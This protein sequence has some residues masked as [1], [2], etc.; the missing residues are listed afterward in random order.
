M[1]D[2]IFY[3]ACFKYI[4]SFKVDLQ[5]IQSK[6]G[7]VLSGKRDIRW[8]VYI[9]ALGGS[10]CHIVQPNGHGSG[11]AASHAPTIRQ[12]VPGAAV[13]WNKC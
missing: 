11:A 10:Q 12:A 8:R 7:R 4:E 6:E 1:N 13:T 3:T 2:L 9:I 5:I